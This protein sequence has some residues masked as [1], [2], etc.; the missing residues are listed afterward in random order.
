MC[1]EIKV[2]KHV[3]TSSLSVDSAK[4]HR[5]NMATYMQGRLSL[6]SDDQI[7][8]HPSTNSHACR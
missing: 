6:S 2:F 5:L 7:E 3:K 4:R 1:S 8:Q